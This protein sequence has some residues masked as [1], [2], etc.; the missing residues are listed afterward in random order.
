MVSSSSPIL[1]TPD[2][3]KDKCIRILIADRNRMASHLLAESLNR[4]PH[5]EVTCVAAADEV[6]SSALT[7]KPDVAVISAEFDGGTKT[8]LQI[9]RALNLRNPKIDIVVLIDGNA[10]GAVLA[11]FRCGAKGVFSRSEPPAEFRA[12]IERVS[13]G[14]I[15]AGRREAEYLLAAVRNSPSC[16]GI[17]DEKVSVLSKRELEVAECAAQG[18]SN[19]QIAD[20]LHLSEHTVKNY[21]FRIFDKLGVSN[22]FE[23]LFLLYNARD[24][25]SRK[26]PVKP[27]R[28]EHTHIQKCLK[29]AEA[30]FAA[31]QFSLGLAYLGQSGFERNTRSAYY[32]L[33]MA[34]HS[35]SALQTRCHELAEELKLKLARTEIEVVETTVERATSNNNK[36]VLDGDHTIDAV[37]QHLELLPL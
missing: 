19:K 37:Q 36:R 26:E 13:G 3:E 18:Q 5:L 9:V 10:R 14:E 31:A 17:D 27:A 28:L 34:E 30:G 12:C 24:N 7:H 2:P 4:D 35:S 29:A 16:D 20:Q 6:L 33:R 15:W 22:R 32:W 1:S 21:L 25:L 11:A 8:G 23:L